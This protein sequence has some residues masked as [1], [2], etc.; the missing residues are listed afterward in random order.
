MLKLD[1]HVH[2]SH[3]VDGMFSVREMVDAAK[4]KGLSGMAITDHNTISGL[5]EAAGL[6]SNKFLVIPGVEI[7]SGGAHVVALG[8]KKE[9]P[10]GMP[11]KDTVSLIK[12]QGGVAIA[13]HP[14][15]PGRNPD[16]VKEVRFDAI[17]GLNSRAFFLSNPL[18]RRYSRL[19]NLP[20]VAGS[21]AHHADDVGT[22]YTC[23]DCRPDIETVLDEIRA[24]RTSIEGKALPVPTLLWRFVQRA[25]KKR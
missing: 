8:I 9:I 22:A 24:G 20:M 4:R 14:F 5:K 10:K 18:A 19:T 21:D 25:L 23:I 2:T 16:A 6:S 3:S 15:V 7:S 17:E 12:K 11:L 13:A 1:L